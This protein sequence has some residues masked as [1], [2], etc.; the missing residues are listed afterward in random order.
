MLRLYNT[1]TKRK[2]RFKPLSEGKVTMYNCGLTVYDYAHIGNLRAFA[3]ADVL[4][5][6]L[7]YK[8]FEV[9]QVMNFTD[10]GH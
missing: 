6:Y 1:L 7:E 2:Q 9:K 10:V 5:R 8:G 3:F 4:R